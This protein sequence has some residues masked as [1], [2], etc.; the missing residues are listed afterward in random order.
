MGNEVKK[1]ST[2][3]ELEVSQLK[4]EIMALEREKNSAIQ[5]ECAKIRRDADAY[6][7]QMNTQRT[8]EDAKKMANGNKA[9]AIAEGE[10]SA[11]FAARRAH[12]AEM[13]RLDILQEVTQKSG[14]KIATSQENTVGLSAD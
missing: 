14:A 10:A 2:A 9:L 8:V 1:I 3:A 5:S 13:K 4:S 12:E 7:A 6:A 11:A